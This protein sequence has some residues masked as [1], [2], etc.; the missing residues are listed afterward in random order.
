MRILIV[1]CDYDSFLDEF[2]DRYPGLEA[3][4][5]SEQTDVRSQQFFGIAQSYATHLACLGYETAVVY[6]NNERA[7]RAWAREYGPARLRA[8][9]GGDSAAAQLAWKLVR[10]MPGMRRTGLFEET[11][12]A[13]VR[14]FAPDVFMCLSPVL[15][16]PQLVSALRGSFDLAIGQHAA[17][18]L[19]NI[20]RLGCYD[21]F[22]SSFPPT[23]DALRRNAVTAELF[24][25]GFDPDVLQHIGA[26][27]R[28]YEIA[29]VGNFFP[30][31]HD[32]R[33]RLIETLCEHFEGMRVWSSTIDGLAPSSPIRARYAGTAWGLEMFKVLSR[34][35]I[36][37]NHHGDIPPFANNCRLYEATGCG[38]LLVTDARAGLS[39]IFTVGKELL[40]YENSDECIALIERSLRD[41]RAATELAQ[42]GRAR[43]LREHTY[44]LRMLELIDRVAATRSRRASK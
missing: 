38:A 6:A 37:L 5:Y 13:Q 21:L 17:T 31:V 10:R 3:A 7:Q 23:V 34:S 18:A 32:S 44:G 11:L 41:R 8:L 35:R 33:V 30:G 42:A 1:D 12:A 40:E 28:D 22:L 15:V 25:L 27:E 26:P 24:R 2:Y 19:P 36:V 20:G 9:A 43:T 4:A 14:R 39:Q 29:F 16:D